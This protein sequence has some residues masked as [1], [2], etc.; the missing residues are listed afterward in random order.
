MTRARATT[1]IFMLGASLSLAACGKS[2]A[3]SQAEAAR[4]TT[5]YTDQGGDVV[6]KNA[7]DLEYAAKLQAQAAEAAQDKR[8]NAAATSTQTEADAL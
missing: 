1:M 8:A 3:Q 7:V 5:I 6:K 4:G 2:A